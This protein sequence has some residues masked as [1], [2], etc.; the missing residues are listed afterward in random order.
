MLERC[1]RCG[2]RMSMLTGMPLDRRFY[3]DTGRY[4]GRCSSC[5]APMHLE[6][7]LSSKLSDRK[8]Q[9]VLRIVLMKPRTIK[10]QPPACYLCR[11]CERRIEGPVFDQ[12]VRGYESAKRY[13]DLADL[14]EA[15]GY[16]DLGT[17]SRMRA[18]VGDSD[19][20]LESLIAR[21]AS[22]DRKV[23]YLCPSCGRL[24]QIDGRTDP[25]RLRFCGRCGA[26]WDQERLKQHLLASLV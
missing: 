22:N 5:E 4:V 7:F 14:Y 18:R 19:L 13:D 15:F 24:I 23:D 8:A 9:Q 26:R 25:D 6:C 12:A 16:L 3:E 20:D 17:K 10:G 2:E 1:G 11:E 21:L